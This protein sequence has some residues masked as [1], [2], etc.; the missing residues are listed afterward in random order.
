MAE[1]ELEL[2]PAIW[3][4]L[5]R[6]ALFNVIELSDLPTQINWSCTSRELFLIVSCMIWG[7]LRVRSSAVTAYVAIVSG[8]RLTDR[9]DG[10]VHFLLESAYRRHNRWSHVFASD[11]TRGTFILRPFGMEPYLDRKQL[12]ATL[13]VSH[14]KHLQID[15]QGFDSKHPVCYQ[16]DMEQVLTALLRRLPNLQSF[17][18]LGPLS[19]KVLAAIIQIDS[20]R[21]LQLRNGNDVLKFP[22]PRA[23]TRIIP[24]IDFALDWSAL[25]CLKGLQALEIGRLT[26]HEAPLL[27]SVVVSL[28]LQRLH[29]SCWGWEYENVV[30]T[31]AMSTPGYTSALV[32]F[33]DALMTLDLRDGRT[34]HGFPSTLKHLV[35]IEKYDVAIPSLHQL[36]AT[37]IL[38]CVNLETLSTT[39]SV[40]GQCHNILSKMGL[41]AYH[42]IIGLGSWQQLSCDEGMKLLHQYRSPSGELLQTNPYAKPLR[43][44]V[45]TLDRVIETAEG[46]G[47]YRMSMKFVKQ[48]DL[49]RD[50]ILIY[51][52]KGEHVPSAAE[53]GPHA[54]DAEMLDLAAVFGALSLEESLW[55]YM[56]RSWGSWAQW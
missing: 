55:A 18:F 26:H 13:P 19:P 36:I 49:R 11:R 34:C 46:P 53:R 21:E 28:K 10:I 31:I 45:E 20:L 17:N 47:H 33:L 9:T 12:T 40:N 54:Q 1:F 4:N 32:M 25:A 37:A 38:P 5:P 30:P 22:A 35:L 15:N 52:C 27:A 29:L 41:P 14:I 6:D 56:L 23:P 8:H 24:W 39:I 2:D 48:R 42:K 44:I 16:V 51:P 50:E 7:L 43:N 3:S